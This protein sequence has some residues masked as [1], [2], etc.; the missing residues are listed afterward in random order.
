M[1][2]SSKTRIVSALS[3]AAMAAFAI[4]AEAPSAMANDNGRDIGSVT[5]ATKWV[6]PNH[7]IKVSAFPDPK[8]DGVTCFLSRPI[9]GG[10]SGGL[11]IAE[12]KSDASIAC[13]QTGPIKFKE[14]IENDEDGEEVFNEDRSLLFKNLHVTR[15]FD[16][17]SNSLVYL[18]YSKKL[19][20]GSPK[21]AISAVTM[22]P[23]GTEMPGEPKLAQ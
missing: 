17:A 4:G 1:T 15:F 8:V 2:K 21:N 13:R 7:K 18:T 9:T 3:G 6:G 23:W 5:T 12:D 19:F 20:D 16:E 14:A 11:G 22:M 10:I